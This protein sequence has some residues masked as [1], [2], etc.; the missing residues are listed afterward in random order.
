[1]VL[2]V[3]VVMQSWRYT[4][5]MVGALSPLGGMPMW[6]PHSAVVAGFALIALICLRHLLR[7]GKL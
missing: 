7:G 3:F 4:A 6:L 5:Q 1:M 2:A